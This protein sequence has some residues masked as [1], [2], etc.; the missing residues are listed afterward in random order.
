MTDC[1]LN[2]Q[3]FRRASQMTLSIINLKV[4]Q[5]IP[6][7]TSG[8]LVLWSGFFGGLGMRKKKRK[9]FQ[10]K[11]KF[12]HFLP[13]KPTP[14]KNVSVNKDCIVPYSSM[15]AC[16]LKHISYGK[17]QAFYRGKAKQTVHVIASHDM[18][19]RLE[20]QLPTGG[21]NQVRDKLSSLQLLRYWF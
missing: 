11:K 15:P 1:C 12:T 6:S 17:R 9:K 5:N 16:A 8:C 19:Q 14:S 20:L 3:I 13:L 7:G 2:W 4:W 18:T 10:K 21:K